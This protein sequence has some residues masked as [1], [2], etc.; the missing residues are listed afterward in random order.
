MGKP[1]YVGK[2]LTSIIYT[3]STSQIPMTEERYSFIM[4]KSGY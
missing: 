2:K 3:V 4:G 1:Y